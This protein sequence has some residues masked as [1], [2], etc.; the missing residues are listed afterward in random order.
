MIVF[1]TLTS[2]FGGFVLRWRRE[3]LSGYFGPRGSE[4]GIFKF[5]LGGFLVWFLGETCRWGSA[6]LLAV[7]GEWVWAGA[8]L[9]MSFLF[10]GPLFHVMCRKT[11]IQ[12]ESSVPLDVSATVPT[13]EPRTHTASEQMPPSQP[14]AAVSVQSMR[15]TEKPQPGTTLKYDL[16]KLCGGISVERAIELLRGACNKPD[17]MFI[18]DRWLEPRLERLRA[19]LADPIT[20]DQAQALLDAILKQC[21][22]KDVLDWLGGDPILWRDYQ[23]RK[24]LLEKAAKRAK[25]EET[26]RRWAN[27]DWDEVARRTAA[28]GHVYVP[29]E[30]AFPRMKVADSNLAARG[31]GRTVWFLTPG[32]D[33][34]FPCED[35]D[36]YYT[37]GAARIDRTFL[38][39][40]LQDFSG[41]TVP[42]DFHTSGRS[43]DSFTEWVVKESSRWNQQPLG[44]VEAC[45]VAGIL[46]GAFG[47]S[48]IKNGPHDKVYLKFP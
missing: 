37:H 17:T 34:P 25:A 21:P 28:G 14:Q 39:R 12:R 47:V 32:K 26:R 19:G 46:C 33:Q 1:L 10:T 30:V 15:P 31:A 48:S 8:A 11:P 7:N 23:A 40:A 16:E 2:I 35:F 45:F 27:C 9:V 22:F 38:T 5:A 6:V 3:S 24:T 41:K 4:P 36:T 13:R 18:T 20:A 42:A 44:A 29:P 43:P